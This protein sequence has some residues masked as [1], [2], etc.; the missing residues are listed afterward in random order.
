MSSRNSHTSSDIN[1][2]S[3]PRLPSLPRRLPIIELI[4]SEAILDPQVKQHR[5]RGQF[6]F[7]CGA[8]P[9]ALA[10]HDGQLEIVGRCLEWF[11]FD[12]EIPELNLTP[13]QHWLNN[14]IDQLDEQQRLDAIDCMEFILG[15]FE[16]DKVHP[17]HGFSA[18]DLLRP[19]N[20]YRVCE[21]VINDEICPGQM[22]LGRIFPHRDKYLL[23]G[24]AT[25]MDNAATRQLKHF[26]STGKLRPASI[27][28]DIDGLELENLLGRSLQDIDRIENI[29]TLHRRMRCY[30][31][32]VVPNRLDFDQFISLLNSS[33]DP[34]D[35]AVR[36]CRQI[37]I[38]CRHEIELIMAYIMTCWFKNQ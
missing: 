11:V 6:T 1:H 28:V 2:D 5:R 21:Q 19:G 7:F 27:L 38:H 25:I 29:D 36:V 35:I 10:G 23:S 32:E 8:E 15:I 14:N 3:A 13:A 24:M 22:L 31:E 17:K 4:M 26:I 33:D 37:D 18:V 30:L 34:V 20:V 9:D 16:I 12:Y